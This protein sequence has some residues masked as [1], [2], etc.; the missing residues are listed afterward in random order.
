MEVYKIKCFY[1]LSQDT[2]WDELEKP[3]LDSHTKPRSP[4]RLSQARTPH[5]PRSEPETQNSTWIEQRPSSSSPS[6]SPTPIPFICLP[7]SH[8]NYS[9][10]Q[11]LHSRVTQESHSQ[12]NSSII[13][14]NLPKVPQGRWKVQ[15]ASNCSS[16]APLFA[17]GPHFANGLY[18]L[19]RNKN[20]RK[21]R[22]ARFGMQTLAPRYSQAQ[23]RAGISPLLSLQTRKTCTSLLTGCSATKSLDQEMLK[24]H[25][26]VLLKYA[27]K[28]IVNNRAAKKAAP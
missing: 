2:H 6:G 23:G 11:P 3:H 21:C 5:R 28:L 24:R 13:P 19:T 1:P 18:K 26:I 25:V 16:T 8:I 27:H 10:T 17:E 12:N 14:V 15:T 7:R 9:E 22:S 4:E 20:P